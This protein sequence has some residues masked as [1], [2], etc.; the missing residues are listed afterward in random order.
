MTC[1]K[2]CDNCV[3][4]QRFNGSAMRH[5]TYFFFNEHRRPCPAGEGCTAKVGMKVN[6]RQRKEKDNG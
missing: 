5:C 1:D 2:Y 3:Y 4:C 6:R